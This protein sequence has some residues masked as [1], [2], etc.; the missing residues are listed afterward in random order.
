MRTASSR[1]VLLLTVV[2]ATSA[3]SLIAGAAAYIR[4][5]GTLAGYDI[6]AT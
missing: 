2:M 6:K 3:W 1:S 5:Q 4:N